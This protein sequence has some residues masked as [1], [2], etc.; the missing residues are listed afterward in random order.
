MTK[1]PRVH[2]AH[3]LECV[4][5]IEL[6]TA[7]GKGRFMLDPMIQDATTMLPPISLTLGFPSSVRP[8]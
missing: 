5:K 1:D 7:D 8:T 2:F 4:Q 6:F 3:I